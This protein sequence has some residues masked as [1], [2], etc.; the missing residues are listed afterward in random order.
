MAF[1]PRS[2]SSSLPEWAEGEIRVHQ[3]LDQTGWRSA[4]W[5]GMARGARAR[6]E[7]AARPS[8]RATGASHSARRPTSQP[9][10]LA[11][12]QALAGNRAAA[13]LVRAQRKTDGG[14]ADKAWAKGVRAKIE[15]LQDAALASAASLNADA[16]RA[17]V[18]LS[19]AQQT[20]TSFEARYTRASSRFTSSVDAAVKQADEIRAWRDAALSLALAA[21]GGPEVLAGKVA[22]KVGLEA[23]TGKEL[24]KAYESAGKVTEKVTQVGTV[25]MVPKAET[26]APASTKIG[27]SA[28]VDWAALLQVTLDAFSK[29]VK[30]NR[31][32]NDIGSS[33]V[34]ATRFLA[35]VIESGSDGAAQTRPEAQSAQH[36]ADGADRAIADLGALTKISLAEPAE[37][38]N[39]VAQARVGGLTE[40][41]I[42][43]DIAIKWISQLDSGQ[44]GAVDDAEG[45]FQSLEVIGPKSRLGTEV[46]SYWT[47]EWDLARI[48]VAAK[49]EAT[50][51][52]LV[53]RSVEWLGGPPIFQ[54]VRDD[55]GRS[56]VARALP[57]PG[58]TL[59]VQPGGFCTVVGYEVPPMTD[60]QTS[61]WSHPSERR[62]AEQIQGAATLIVRPT[63]TLGGGLLTQGPVIRAA[64]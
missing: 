24:Y 63:E 3:H 42:E 33:C 37:L 48:R 39:A 28:D 14:A 17:V 49:V 57:V 13:S 60:D 34:S 22:G 2:G 15:K 4:W 44:M 12:V 41:K 11:Q 40:R 61:E 43:Q 58:I 31:G 53:G 18:A 6:R 54:Q 9:A 25:L 47:T 64:P 36:L 23:A 10:P 59:T 52:G 45:Y 62:L 7:T 26:T 16:D 51:M 55:Y 5:L 30:G 8:S 32:L 35:G 21:V 1:G 19:E 46:G 50:L 27:P 38:F 29:Y 56:W 20:F